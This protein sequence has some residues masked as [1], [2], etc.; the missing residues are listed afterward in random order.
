MLEEISWVLRRAT[1]SIEPFL[2][3]V[4]KHPH[5]AFRLLI[6][7][8]LLL[9][10]LNKLECVEVVILELR[11]G[12][13]EVATKFESGSMAGSKLYCFILRSQYMLSLQG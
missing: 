11:S 3:D 5:H 10:T 12:G 7:K 13:T 2:D 9:Q 6:S 8:P 4:A 1:R